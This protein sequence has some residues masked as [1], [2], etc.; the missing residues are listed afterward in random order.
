MKHYYQ[1]NEID[2]HGYLVKEAD[3][4][5]KDKL[6]ELY[7]DYPD[8][9]DKLVIIHGYSHGDQLLQMVRHRSDS[10]IRRIRGVKGNPGMT[11]YDLYSWDELIDREEKKKKN[12]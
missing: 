7:Q 8:E 3:Q 6:D 4:I 1:T 5:I 11:V 10:R 12:R 2:L 9:F